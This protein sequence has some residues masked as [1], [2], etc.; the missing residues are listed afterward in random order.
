MDDELQMKAR[1]TSTPEVFVYANL[2]DNYQQ[3]MS[4]NPSTVE[5]IATF[6]V[7]KSFSKAG[8]S[9]MKVNY[10]KMLPLSDT[11]IRIP[12][13]MGLAYSMVDHTRVMASLKTQLHM[14]VDMPAGVSTIS[15]T[16]E[17][18]IFSNDIINN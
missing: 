3:L 8:S 14:A 4:L 16:I 12:S 10:H 11:F 6:L 13:S 7:R 15:S 9:P 1:A 18:S 17:G 2:L 5:D